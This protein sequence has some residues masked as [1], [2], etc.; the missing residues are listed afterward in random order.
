MMIRSFFAIVLV[1]DVAEMSLRRAKDVEG[2]FVAGRP[3]LICYESKPAQ[4]W[5]E[6]ESLD[7]KK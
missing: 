6:S 1:M 5:I 3:D 2:I 4:D 7:R